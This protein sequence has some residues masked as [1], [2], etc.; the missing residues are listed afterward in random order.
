MTDHGAGRPED[1]AAR[2]EFWE[3]VHHSKD[4]DGV[5]WW[6]SVPGLSLGLVDDTGLGPHEPIIDVGAGWSTL[7]DHLLERGYR[8]LT[9]IDLS[10]TALQTVRDRLGPAGKDVQLTMADVLDL[11]M[12]RQYALW[13]DRAVYH[14][15]TEPEERDDYRASLERSLRPGGWLVVATFGP[16]GPTTCSGLPIVRYTHAQLADQFPGFQLIDTAGEDHLTPWGTSQ[17][18]TA[19]LLRRT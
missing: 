17:Q 14:F 8:D 6:Q 4:V 18:F 19:V 12:G 13:H 3:G 1:A 2:T 16:D 10:V 7:V 11:D 15:L 9:A 5:S